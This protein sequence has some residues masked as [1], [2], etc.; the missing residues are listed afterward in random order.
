MFPMAW[1]SGVPIFSSKGQRSRS[2]DVKTAKKI[3]RHLYSWVAASANQVQQVLT[4]H[5]AYAI[6]RPTL[7]SAPETLGDGTD[8]HKCRCRELMFYTGIEFNT[9]LDKKSFTLRYLLPSQDLFVRRRNLRWRN[10]RHQT[11]QKF[12]RTAEN[13]TE[14]YWMVLQHITCVW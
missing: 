12:A 4:S 13:L 7:L 6:V 3:W 5:L 9:A 8:G 2:R 11:V 14:A 10:F 1:V